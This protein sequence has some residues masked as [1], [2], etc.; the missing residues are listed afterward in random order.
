MTLVPVEDDEKTLHKELVEGV[1]LRNWA[2]RA[3]PEAAA[4]WNETVGKVLGLTAPTG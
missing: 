1:V 3:G 4:R 2:E